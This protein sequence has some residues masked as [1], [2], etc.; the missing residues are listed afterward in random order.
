MVCSSLGIAPALHVARLA[1]W[2]D[3]DGPLWLAQDRS[4]VVTAQDGWLTPPSEG[5]W[6]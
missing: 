2:V 6:G 1:D 4:G 3:L 5:F